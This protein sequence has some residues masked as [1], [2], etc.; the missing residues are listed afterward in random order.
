[1]NTE[2][3]AEIRAY[4]DGTA[5]VDGNPGNEGTK[6]RKEQKQE[7][8]TAPIVMDLPRPWPNVN[9]EYADPRRCFYCE[10]R[11]IGRNDFWDH[12]YDKHWNEPRPA[13]SSSQEKTNP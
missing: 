3:L 8:A 2:R 1:V 6:M 10:A 7:G 12:V 4:V 13:S 11:F 9:G 5:D